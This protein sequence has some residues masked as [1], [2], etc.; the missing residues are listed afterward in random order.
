MKAALTWEDFQEFCHID[1]KRSSYLH[2]LL[3]R[4]NL[5]FRGMAQGEAYNILI[6][7]G[8]Q[9]LSRLDRLFTAHYDRI[10]G[11]FGANDNSAAVFQLLHHALHL[12]ENPESN[13]TAI[14]LTDRE[15]F[16][17]S[18]REEKQGAYY[19]ARNFRGAPFLERVFLF[20]MCGIGNKLLQSSTFHNKQNPPQEL[21]KRL[22][23]SPFSP[24][25]VPLPFSDDLGFYQAG[26]FAQLFSL[27]PQGELPYLKDW[28]T[29]QGS[30][31]PPE[32]Y[33]DYKNRNPRGQR[34]NFP[35]SWGVNHTLEDTIQSL[36]PQSFHLM[37]DFLIYLSALNFS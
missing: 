26:V 23:D 28:K 17:F 10:K 15:E 33:R 6:I 25:S 1:C 3:T 36:Q 18:R 31:S 11:T 30:P 20:D 29:S 9:N 22:E 21:K 16:Q 13:R 12:Q 32:S 14:L 19:F 5:P 8:H 37:K 27:L 35:P 4:L 7:P 24:L 34:E 2:R